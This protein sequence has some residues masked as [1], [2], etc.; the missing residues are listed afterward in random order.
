MPVATAT[1]GRTLP[2]SGDA[3]L[4]APAVVVD[5]G[6]L[7]VAQAAA[8]GV[9]GGQ[10]DRRVA[11]GGAVAW[12]VG[13]GRVEELRTRR[14]EELERV[15]GRQVGA[16]LRVLARR[17]V[18]RQRVEARRPSSARSRARTCPRAWGRRRRR[19]GRNARG[20]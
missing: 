20:G 8:R 3:G 2:V 6:P 7:A 4:E 12:R 10:L 5:L 9:L 16:G 1:P 18:R 14:A 15:P 17:D 19:T 11:G 13:E